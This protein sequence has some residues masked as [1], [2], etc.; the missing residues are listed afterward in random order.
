ME[1][2]LPPNH[3]NTEKRFPVVYLH[4]CKVGRRLGHI[5]QAVDLLIRQKRINP[6]L[7]VLVQENAAGYYQEIF[8]D[9]E[10]MQ[11]YAEMFVEEIVLFIDQNYRTVQDP[12]GR[13]NIGTGFSGCVDMYNG[14]KYPNKFAHLAGQTS[15]FFGIGAV[16]N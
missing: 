7:L 12:T 2:Y 16:R 5:D 15:V 3:K 9:T 13:I 1:I 8:W 14:L 4:L 10:S 11:K 6:I